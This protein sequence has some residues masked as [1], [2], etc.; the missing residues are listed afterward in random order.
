MADLFRQRLTDAVEARLSFRRSSPGTL[1]NPRFESSSSNIKV[2]V[3]QTAE[4]MI[5]KHQGCS[6]KTDPGTFG[7]AGQEAE[8]EADVSDGVPAAEAENDEILAASG[9]EWMDGH[10]LVKDALVGR[11][12]CDVLDTSGEERLHG[13]N[14]EKKSDIINYKA[15]VVKKNTYHGDEHLHESDL[16]YDADDEADN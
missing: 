7:L 6:D 9:R 12:G 14:L 13:Y 4:N 3:P 15:E 1:T 8:Y 5:T 11:V 16:G 2:H 10:V